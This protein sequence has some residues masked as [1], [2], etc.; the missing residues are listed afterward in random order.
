[1]QSQAVAVQCGPSH[2]GPIFGS[3]PGCWWVL[4]AVSPRWNPFPGGKLLLRLAPGLQPFPLLVWDSRTF[5]FHGVH[6]LKGLIS[7]GRATPPFTTSS[8]L[9]RHLQ[10][11]SLSTSV[12][13]FSRHHTCFNGKRG[14]TW[15]T[16][17][18]FNPSWLR[19]HGSGCTRP[20]AMWIRRTLYI[21]PSPPTTHTHT[22]FTKLLCR[23]SDL[24]FYSWEIMLS[25]W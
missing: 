18:G 20:W 19:R 16:P 25:T 13:P 3:V 1:M 4:Q 2:H 5:Q 8:A 10:T 24:S 23:F 9:P 14:S 6:R 22:P 11:T 7:H 17:Q 21:V 12:H 15:L